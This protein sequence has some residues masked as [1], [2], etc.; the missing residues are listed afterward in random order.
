MLM[1]AALVK[2]CARAHEDGNTV[3]ATGWMEQ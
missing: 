1:R 2:A 3:P